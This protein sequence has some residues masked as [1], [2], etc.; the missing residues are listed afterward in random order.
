MMLRLRTELW[1]APVLRLR[2]L[3]PALTA[4][5]GELWQQFR[6][7]G[8]RLVGIKLSELCSDLLTSPIDDCH[9]GFAGV[10][11]GK[12]NDQVT[13]NFR[14]RALSPGIPNPCVF[15]IAAVGRAGL[16]FDSWLGRAVCVFVFFLA[17]GFFAP[18]DR[19]F[20]LATRS[21]TSHQTRR[22][23]EE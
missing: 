17:R 10:P 2:P 9:G 18:R 14:R 7:F 22:S 20:H 6:A 4:P 16:T 8:P 11:P 3:G 19:A 15:F 21:S 13:N 1:T 12:R 23:A 5:A